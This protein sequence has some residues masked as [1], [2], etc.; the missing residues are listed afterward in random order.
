[1]KAKRLLAAIFVLLFVFCTGTVALASEEKIPTATVTIINSGEF[2]LKNYEVAV[3]G[4]SFNI[5]DALK[6]AHD[7]KYEGGADKG[8]ASAT[9]DYGLYIT[10][11]WGDESGAFGYAVNN[12]MSSGLSDKVAAGDSVVVYI[13]TDKTGYSD[14]YTYFNINK[15]SVKAGEELTL[16]L[17]SLG[18]DESW[19]TVVSPLADATITVDGEKTEFK[20]DADGKVT[21]SLK[22]GK[23]YTVSASA[24][25]TIVPPLCVVTVAKNAT[26]AVLYIVIAVIV[27]CGAAAIIIVGSKKK[28][29]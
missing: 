16:T 13:Y 15:A 21:L 17:S 11:L 2:V 24:D 9:G 18:Y 19:N 26:S 23:T 5:D 8:Y 29:K 27:V 22:G 12:K 14:K 25:G 3:N 4:E 1:M 7:A 6:A 28:N 10:K 20:T